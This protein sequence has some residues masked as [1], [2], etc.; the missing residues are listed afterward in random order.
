VTERVVLVT[1]FTWPSVEPEAAVLA[2][3]GARLLVAET[4]EETEL[5][6]LVTDADAILT[7]FKQVSPAVV[8]AGRRLQVMNLHESSSTRMRWGTLLSM[9]R[10]TA[11][12]S[13]SRVVL[14]PCRPSARRVPRCFGFTP[15][16]D[17]TWVTFN[18][19]TRPR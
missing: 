19:I 8:R 9:P 11:V 4:G 13:C 18:F 6:E 5:L 15:I 7:C 17:R 2:A 16:D 14:I 12:S 3:A 1:D 10:I